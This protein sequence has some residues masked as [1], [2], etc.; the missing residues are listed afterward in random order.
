MQLACKHTLEN[1]LTQ[2]EDAPMPQAAP[3]QMPAALTATPAHALQG[4][5]NVAGAD[6]DEQLPAWLQQNKDLDS[7]I[8]QNLNDGPRRLKLVKALTRMALPFQ[9]PNS[10]VM[11]ALGDMNSENVS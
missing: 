1:L 3:L 2:P 7:W 4:G 9:Y 8:L 11:H 6:T 5:K 10:T